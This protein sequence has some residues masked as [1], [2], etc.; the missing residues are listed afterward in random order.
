VGADYDEQDLQN[1][2]EIACRIL[3]TEHLS[4]D[5]DLYEAGLTSIM[6]LPLLTELES[7]FQLTI[8]D[9]HFLDAR[10]PRDLAQMIRRLR[11]T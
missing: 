1:V 8:S 6:A 2:T 5:E 7:T 9:A 11:A 3:N 10:T 4:A